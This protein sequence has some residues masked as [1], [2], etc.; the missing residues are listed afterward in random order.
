M[1]LKVIW[2]LY[3]G[4]WFPSGTRYPF[5]QLLVASSTNWAQLSSSPELPFA[6]GSCFAQVYACFLGAAC[7]QWLDVGVE[8]HDSFLHCNKPR[9]F[10]APELP[11]TSTGDLYWNAITGQSFFLPNPAP[12]I[13]S[14][15]INHLCANFRDS[16][17]ALGFVMKMIGTSYWYRKLT[18]KWGSQPGL[19]G[20]GLAIKILWEIE[21]LS[22][23]VVVVCAPFL[24]GNWD[25]ILCRQCAGVHS[26][27]GVWWIW[28]N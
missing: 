21:Q 5:S 6:G 17:G 22:W 10:L 8:S 18:L 2:G 12:F 7:V 13:P 19:L 23:H 25:R 16:A 11:I 3:P 14:S 9:A 28:R 20:D 24:V 1:F 4:L 27:L 26:I 15:F